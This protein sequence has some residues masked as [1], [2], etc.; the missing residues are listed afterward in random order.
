MPEL[1]ELLEERLKYCKKLAIL[2][3]GS[4]LLA[5]DAAGIMIVTRLKEIFS[6]EVYPDLRI[7]LGYTAPENFTGEIK[8]FNPCHLII[9][10]AAD[11]KEE[12]GSVMVIQPDVISGVSFS[13]H[14]LPL[15]VMAEY[16]KKETG[17]EMTILGIQSVDV[18]YGG[19][20][21]PKVKEAVDEI[22]DIMVE[23]IKNMHT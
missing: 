8:K 21:T 10:D 13:T 1:K 14:M 23:V 3:A 18:S 16:L 11:M 17:C 5:D 15:K 4:V 12:P 19:E 7:Y 9:I 20:V 2:G 6:E 22:T